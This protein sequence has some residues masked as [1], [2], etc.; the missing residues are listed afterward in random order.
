MKTIEAVVSNEFVDKTL[1]R[2]ADAETPA[3]LKGELIYAMALSQANG[4][5][6]ERKQI[7]AWLRAQAGLC[8]LDP[9]G[10]VLRM[11]ADEIERGEHEN[12]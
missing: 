2:M 4:R 5:L 9:H 7:V 8:G 11:Q 6:D 3:A 10:A 12:R 1:E